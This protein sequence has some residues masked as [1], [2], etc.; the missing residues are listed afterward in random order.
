M[1]FLNLPIN[2]IHR[3]AF[4][5]CFSVGDTQGVE[6]HCGSVATQVNAYR[7]VSDKPGW[8]TAGTVAKLREPFS[9]K[10]FYNILRRTRI[11]KLGRLKRCFC[12]IEI[13]FWPEPKGR[14]RRKNRSSDGDRISCPQGWVHAREVLSHETQTVQRVVKS[15]VAYTPGY[16]RRVRSICK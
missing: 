11:S 9:G 16:I 14:P 5:S 3:V 6:Q 13:L 12:T 8:N 7:C 1:V 2:L 15:R 10:S 4:I